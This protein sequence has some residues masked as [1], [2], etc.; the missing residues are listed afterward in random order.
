V[1]LS[2][3]GDVRSGVNTTQVQPFTSLASVAGAEV[4]LVSPKV[5]VSTKLANSISLINRGGF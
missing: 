3:K 5:G 1:I 4:A 2:S